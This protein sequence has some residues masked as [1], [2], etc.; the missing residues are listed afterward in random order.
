MTSSLRHWT[1]AALFFAMLTP[2]ATEAQSDTKSPY[3]SVSGFYVIPADTKLSGSIDDP[4]ISYSAEADMDGNVGLMAAI[5]YGSD[6][7]LRGEIEFGYRKSDFNDVHWHLRYPDLSGS[8]L[9][10][11]HPLKGGMNSLSLMANGIYI[12]EAWR[13][14]PYLGVGVGLVRHDAGCRSRRT[15]RRGAR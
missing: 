4:M 10:V 1:L 9:Q 12:F 14:R 2:I 15:D 7:G 8:L 3:I 5:G 6:L 11:D 13:F